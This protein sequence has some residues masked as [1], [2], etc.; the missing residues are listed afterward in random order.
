MWTRKKVGLKLSKRSSAKI[1]RSYG[2]VQLKLAASFE[3]PLPL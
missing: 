1:H 2:T 3:S